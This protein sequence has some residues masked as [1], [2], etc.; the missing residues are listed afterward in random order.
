MLSHAQPFS[1]PSPSN[2]NTLTSCAVSSQTSAGVGA[3]VGGLVGTTTGAGVGAGVG[4]GVGAR[5]GGLVGATTGAAVGARVG[6]GVG[7]RVGGLVG[8]TTGAGVGARVGDLVGTTTGAGV[9]AGVGCGVGA[10]VGGLVGTT[11]GAGVGARVG[12][13]VGAR[14]G[15]LVGTTTGAGVGASVGGRLE[16]FSHVS[17]QT[18][19]ASWP[20]TQ[21]IAI[22]GGRIASHEH[23][24][25]PMVL[26]MTTEASELSSQKSSQRPHDSSHWSYTVVPGTQKNSFCAAVRMLSHAHVLSRPS[27]S[28]TLIVGGASSQIPSL[29]EGATTG[30]SVVGAVTGVWPGQLEL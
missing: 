17:L 6:C 28:N 14:V 8:T 27:N 7:A 2:V 16:Q 26:L 29:I 4:C 21:T 30:A 9:G 22:H 23:G 18:S 12:C 13:G 19:Y 15:G 11:T 1:C 24:F 3:R 5:V 10:R 25:A 20:G